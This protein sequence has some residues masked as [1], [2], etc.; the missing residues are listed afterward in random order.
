MQR[1]VNLI[2]PSTLMVSLPSGWV[3]KYGIK[4]GDVIQVE[5]RGNKLVI[6]PVTA[7]QPQPKKASM[8]LSS[9]TTSLA[10]YYLIAAY[11][12]GADEI[13][14][15]C[16]Q[17]T[18]ADPERKKVYK[19]HDFLNLALENM[20]GMEMMKNTPTEVIMKEIAAIKQEELENIIRRVFFTLTITFDDLVQHTKM[21]DTEAL[22]YL[23]EH[24]DN[25]VNAF[26]D[27]C[28]RIMTKTNVTDPVLHSSVLHLEE[29]G[30]ALKY[31]AKQIALKKAD[32]TTQELLT[33]AKELFLKAE[34]YYYKPSHEDL[35]VFDS[36]KRELRAKINLLRH[37]QD[38][39]VLMKIN[40]I[41]QQS[42]ALVRTKLMRTFL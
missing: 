30:D 15:E 26:V 22:Q 25:K 38:P 31:I 11:R 35:A 24:A 6:A 18:I 17:E 29:I 39:I 27:Y 20:V 19:I 33:K 1:K 5:E 14:I 21:A 36:D 7:Y 32:K 4:K 41:M 40:K 3:K 2:G 16:K 12:S 23:Y 42:A 13:H 10:R 34:K 37:I 8:L 28:I 9:A